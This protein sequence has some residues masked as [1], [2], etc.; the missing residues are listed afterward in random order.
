M[1]MEFS[2]T[3]KKN[4]ETAFNQSKFLFYKKIL[5]FQ[6]K[7]FANAG[8]DKEFNCS[9]LNIYFAAFITQCRSVFQYALKEIKHSKFRIDHEK[10]YNDYIKNKPIIKLFKNLRNSEI[11][12]ASSGHQVTITFES[13]IPSKQSVDKKESAQVPKE[14]SESDIQYKITKAITP[15]EELYEKMKRENN[16]ETVKAIERGD[17]IYKD[18]ILDNDNNLFSLCSKYLLAT[19]QFVEY[20]DKMNIIN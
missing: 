2:Y 16:M 10:L 6:G 8:I 7:I 3:S 14:I 19:E 15:D 17:R 12:V 18:I 5:P 9:P 20:C 4:I 13:K 1:G 11:H